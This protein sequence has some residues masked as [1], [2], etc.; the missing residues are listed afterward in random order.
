MT[1]AMLSARRMI[2]ICRVERADIA[3][4]KG[5]TAALFASTAR[6]PGLIGRESYFSDK[7]YCGMV[8]ETALSGVPGASDPDI[9]LGLESWGI[10]TMTA[11]GDEPEFRPLLALASS[12]KYQQLVRERS[13]FAWTLTIAMLV[14]YFGYILLIAF[15]PEFLAQP[16][17]GGTMTIGIPVGIGVIIVG[18]VLTGIYVRRANRH[19]DQLTRDLVEEARL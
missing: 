7:C 12:P 10:W 1:D 8:A 4:S 3:E 19:F 6:P 17:A 5:S 15:N 16:V 9:I 14:I 11:S 2:P 13:K 18:I